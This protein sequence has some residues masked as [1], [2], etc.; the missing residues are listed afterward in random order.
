VNTIKRIAFV[1]ALGVIV[2]AARPN[3]AQDSAPVGTQPPAETP[4]PVVTPPPVEPVAETPATVK[5]KVGAA[6]KGSAA[7]KA[8]KRVSAAEK[9]DAPKPEPPRPIP[10]AAKRATNSFLNDHVLVTWYGN[11]HSTRMGI[12]GERKGADLAEGLRKQA[13]AY[14]KLTSKQVV[15]A[16][17]LVTVVA[18]GQPGQDGKYRRRESANVIRSMLT[19]ARANGFKLILD[20]Q[21]AWSTVA[22]EVNAVRQFLEEPDVYLALDPEFTMEDHQHVPGKIIGTMRAAEINSAIDILEQIIRDKHLPPKVLIVHQFTLNMLP[23]KMQIRPSDLMDI[24]L[25]MDGFGDRTLKLSTYRAVLRQGPLAWTGFKLFY[26][27]DT[28]LFTPADVMKLNP[29]PAVIIY[30]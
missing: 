28:N 21:P 27:Q 2:F 3:G 26:K 5:P 9:A 18:Q 15:M 8:G 11:P 29:Q 6:A 22:D 20:L 10:P 25:D 17:H 4:A 13:D 30:Q 19:E 12:L 14:Q 24:V 1:I 7:S 16:Y 23:S